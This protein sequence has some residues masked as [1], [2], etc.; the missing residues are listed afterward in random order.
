[1]NTKISDF[2][3]A[4]IVGFDKSEG[5]TNRV[6]GTFGY[7]P[8]EYIMHGQFSVK[9]D[10]FSFGVLVLEII[11]GKKNNS[12]YQSK[13]SEHL[14]SYA[15]K[16]WKDGKSLDLVD[17]ALGDC[18][19]KN[20]VTRCIHM[21]LL[22]VQKDFDERPPMASVVLKLNSTSMTLP[23]PHQPAFFVHSEMVPVSNLL[24]PLLWSANGVSISKLYTFLVCRFIG[25]FW[26]ILCVLSRL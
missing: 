14:L 9:S 19:N 7:M 24:A 4:R 16:L 6:V 25:H 17:P 18:F 1:M 12:F 11:S 2:G 5:S 20:E 26:M 22:C 10:V 21:G 15:W 8:P 23:I 3:L 13:N